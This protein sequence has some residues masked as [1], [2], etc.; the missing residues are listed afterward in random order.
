[1]KIITYNLL[2]GG[3]GKRH[4]PYVI[5]HFDP[6]IFLAQESYPPHECG[7]PQHHISQT[8]W[9]AATNWWGTAI[10]VKRGTLTPLDL[11]AF[12]GWLVGIEVDGLL[13]PG[14]D[15]R[16]LRVFSLHAPPKETTSESYPKTVMKM[17]DVIEQNR[18]DGS[19]VI[20]GDFNLLSLGERHHSEKKDGKPWQ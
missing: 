19:L 1:M 7:L 16:R 5:R 12:Q 2:N 13:H 17:L 18:G 3:A 11:K 20:G 9:H 14:F 6:D 15:G 4:W 10:Y 8:V